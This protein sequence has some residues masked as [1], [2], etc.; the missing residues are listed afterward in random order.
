MSIRWIRSVQ[1]DGRPMTLEVMLGSSKIADKCYVRMNQDEE[2]WFHPSTDRR[3]AILRQGI[4][5]LQQ[6]LQGRQVTASNGSAFLW[7]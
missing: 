4:E 5:M 2:Y 6:R 7:H 3:E 1:V